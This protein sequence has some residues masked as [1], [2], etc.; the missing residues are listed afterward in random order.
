MA[1]LKQ[2]LAKIIIEAFKSG[3]KL[4]ICGCGGSAAEAQHM[5]GEL[6]GK[7]TRWHKPL[8][9]I[10]LTT[11]TS[12]LTAMGNDMGVDYIFSRQVEALGNKGDV[13]LALSTSGK[14]VCVLKAIQMALKKE[15]LVID[16]PRE[17]KSTPEIQENQL[18]LIHR[19]CGII[20]ESF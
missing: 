13:L 6:V 1:T 20:E 16:F 19:V 5:T 15:M 17:G 12:I 18:K 3:N 2:K 7:F 8:P 10:A 9:A 11:D 14:S 4:M